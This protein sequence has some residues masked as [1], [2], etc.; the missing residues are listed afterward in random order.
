MHPPSEN[1]ADGP[2]SYQEY[3]HATDSHNT[4]T[5]EPS[6]ETEA[7]AYTR[8][9]KRQTFLQFIPILFSNGTL[10]VEKNALLN[11]ESDTT[12]L[13]KDITKRL[14][15]ERSQQPL[16]VTSALSKSDKIE[17]A[18]VSVTTGASAMKDSSKLSA[19]L[20]NNIDIPVKSRN[21]YTC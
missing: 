6:N 14:N 15:L 16:A 20:A 12:L 3:H 9:G 10:S 21:R 8:I 18:I 13:R 5:F 1:S 4:V 19:W 7:T 11:C 2:H 17:S